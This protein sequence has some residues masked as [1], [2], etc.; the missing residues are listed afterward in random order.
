MLLQV[1]QRRQDG[2][3]DFFRNWTDYK[4]GFGDLSGEIWLGNDNLH[5]LTK[6]HDQKL[7]VELTYND[8]TVYTQFFSIG[9]NVYYNHVH[10]CAYGV[11]II[12][13]NNQLFR[14]GYL[15]L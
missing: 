4:T 12:I 13:N 3:E 7:K 1:F 8:E 9:G 10:N 15:K 2:S 5:L 14:F 11:H 6:G